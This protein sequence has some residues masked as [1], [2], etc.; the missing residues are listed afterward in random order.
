M[1]TLMSFMMLSMIFVMITMSVASA[2]RISEVLAEKS[3]IENPLNPVYEVKDGSIDFK[4]VSFKYNETAEKDALKDVN[5][6]INSGETIGIVGGTGSSKTSLVNLISR[7]YDVTSGEVDV[8]GVDVRNYDLD[9][10]RNNVAVVLQKNVLFSGT[11]AENI[12]WGDKDASLD[13]VKR[14]CKLACAD[15]FIEGFPDKYDTHIDQGGANVSGGQKQRLC[16][17]R[18]LLKKPKVIIFDDSTSAVDT[19]T[20]AM[21]RKSLSENIPDVTKIII[22]Q[23]IAS[24]EHADKIIVMDNGK[25]DAVG[26]HDELLF[27]NEIYTEVYVTQNKYALNEGKGGND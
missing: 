26:T 15:E 2:K 17:A 24:V 23:R 6:H 10:L 27:K 14:V 9:T 5:L 16:I 18:A 7:L 13:E 8:G 11:I 4:N 20:D 21:I 19:K 12:R 22:A 25:I 3:E 1:S